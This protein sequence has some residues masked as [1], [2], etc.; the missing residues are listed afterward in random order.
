MIT[1]FVW[2]NKKPK[3]KR[4]TLIGP[5]ERG[6]LD[7]PEFETISKLLQSAWVQ[8][9]KNGV[10]DQWMLIPLFYLKNVGGPFIFDCDYV[11]FLGLNN[12]PIF[13][14]DVLNTWAEIREQI[15]DNEICIENVIL[16]N[17][18]HILI[19]GKSVYWK[20]WHEAGIL[21]IK[22]LLD[23]KNRFLTLNKLLLKTGLKTPF[24][25]LFGLI[26]AIPYRWKCTLRPGFIMNDQDMEQNKTKEINVVTSKKVRNILIQR[27]FVEPLAS[28]RLCRQGLDSSKLKFNLYAP[29]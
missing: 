23:E 8:R 13:Y 2:N 10:D 29:I 6:G 25:K 4:D 18:K 12:L 14:A 20:E 22:D 9:M 27:K 19:D 3:I 26:S 1:D 21:R 11:K 7:L 28:L 24:T 16:W 17:N 15:S 5:K